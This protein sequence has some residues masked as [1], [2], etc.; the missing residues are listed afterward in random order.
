MWCSSLRRLHQLPA[1]GM[2]F[3]DA[4][5][6]PSRAVRNLGIYMDSALTMRDHVTHTVSRCFGALRQLRSVRQQV[7]T[8]V[9]RSLV[10][11][12]VLSRLD[13]GNAALAGTTLELI[14]RLQSVQNAAARLIF[15]LRRGSHITDALVELHW[16]RVPPACSIQTAVA[17]VQG[18]SW[19][20]PPLPG[21]VSTCCGRARSSQSPVSIDASAAG[22]TFQ[23]RQCW[24]S[25]IS[26]LQRC[27]VEPAPSRH[28]YN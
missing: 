26:G 24:S 27:S 13:Y 7:P 17:D 14:C 25:V 8:S 18:S 10:A 5:V 2:R 22:F 12:L 9:F 16:L 11:A 1:A 19:I 15:G 23:A 3:R 20:S 28:C 4:T 6:F 21:R